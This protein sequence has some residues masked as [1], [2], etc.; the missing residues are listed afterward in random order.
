MKKIRVKLLENVAMMR[1]LLVFQR[2]ITIG[3]YV[4]KS[5]FSHFVSRV[6]LLFYCPSV[7]W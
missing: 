5:S 1:F 4:G 6:L 2:I 3:R 7:R